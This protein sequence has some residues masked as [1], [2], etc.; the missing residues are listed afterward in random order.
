MS[1][2]L[3]TS[4]TKG[5]LVTPGIVTDSLVLKHNYAA[6]GVVPVSD[7]AAYFDG[8]D[9]IDLPAS[10]NF[11]TGTNVTMS[12]WFKWGDGDDTYLFQNQKGTG[13]TNIALT[14]NYNGSSLDGYVSLL[15]WNGSSHDWLTYDG[16]VD[17]S[18]QWHHLAGTTT[19]SAQVLYL[20]GVAVATSSNTFEN[21][22][23][24][25]L[26]TIGAANGGASYQFK[27]YICNVGIWSEALTQAQIKSIMWKNYAGL[28]S[29][30]TENLV[31]WWNL[32][33]ETATDGTAGSGGVKD[34]HGSNHGDLE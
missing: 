6:G 11:V 26:T 2:G 14:L 24:S 12:L 21:T 9:S 23:S 10:T 29:S 32:D 4:L 17:T 25:D 5:G 31:S 7:G 28:T 15:T 16:S 18:G 22:A 8:S 30:E 19:S 27:G 13:Q 3:G 33:E 20:D 1:L 34:S